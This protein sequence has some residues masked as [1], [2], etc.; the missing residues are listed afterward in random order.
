MVLFTW[1]FVQRLQPEVIADDAPISTTTTTDATGSGP[2]DD[3]TPAVE[4]ETTVTTLPA[5][6]AAFLTEIV[7]DR[8]ALAALAAQMEAVNTAWDSDEI[9][10]SDA[11]EQM[12]QLRDEAAVF[13]DTVVLRQPP[14][15]YP[16]VAAGFEDAL[17]AVEA[18]AASADAVLD[19]LRAPDTGQARRAA[20]LE[21]RSA[22]E[23]FNQ[24]VTAMEDAAQSSAG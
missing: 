1:A 24:A 19:G 16:E 13:R 14:A 11:E 9:S 21:F 2:A 3:G 7:S 17:N 12:L 15:G 23:A 8:E 22:V 18:V 5:D 6:V 20:L 4:P 10:Y